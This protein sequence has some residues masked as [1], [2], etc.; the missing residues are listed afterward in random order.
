MRFV[1]DREAKIKGLRTPV[2]I[3]P[4]EESGS[5]IAWDPVE[6]YMTRDKAGFSDI[7]TAAID[8]L[9]AGDDSQI[10]NHVVITDP[11]SGLHEFLDCGVVVEFQFG[12]LC[13]R[14]LTETPPPAIG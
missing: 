13:V 1:V 5:F 14:S 8:A 7:P 11:K 9:E 12:S 2:T 3:L 4:D 10:R 6:G